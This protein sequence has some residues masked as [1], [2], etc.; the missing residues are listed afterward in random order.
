M[1]VLTPGLVFVSCYTS[2]L[3][4]TLILP[5]YPMTNWCKQHCIATYIF[6]FPVLYKH[7]LLRIL[8]CQGQALH[9]A[10]AGWTLRLLPRI[11]GQQRRDKTCKAVHS[12]QLSLAALLPE[13]FYGARV[14]TQLEMLWKEASWNWIKLILNHCSHKRLKHSMICSNSKAYSSMLRST[15]VPRKT[16]WTFNK[17][18]RVFD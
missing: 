10:A 6:T 16:C 8:P 5:I 13:G 3:Q 11:A 18:H 1:S 7:Q 17:L 2:A 14:P 12:T 9:K 15:P 4:F